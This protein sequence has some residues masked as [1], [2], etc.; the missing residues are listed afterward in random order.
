MHPQLPYQIA[1]T[2]IPQIGPVIARE[3][4]QHFGDALSIFQASPAKLRNVEGLGESRIQ[5]IRSFNQFARAEEECRFVENN[6]INTLFMGQ[7]GYPRRLF[8]CADA[9]ILL[10]ARGMADL[11]CARVLAVVGTRVHTD[12]GRRLTEQLIRDLATENVLILSGLAFGIDALAHK[13]ALRQ[14]LPTAAVLAHGLD[15]LYPP[16]HG[17]LAME[18]VQ[19]AGALIT[20]FPSGT[21][22]DRHHFP[23][24]NR[25]VAGLSD[26]VLVV[27]TGDKGGSLITAE[28]AND[29]N[30]DVFAFPGRVNDPRSAGCNELIRQNKAVLI[31]HA[32]DLLQFMNWV[33]S[34]TRRQSLQ[35]SLFHELNPEE[36]AILDLLQTG[37]SRAI[38]DLNILSRL[39]NSAVAAAILSLELKN[40]IVSLPGKMYRLA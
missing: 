6:K 23:A 25:I 15:Y 22:P 30:R 33:E 21:Q 19:H 2:M 24:R 34:S 11:N 40:L 29:Y 36:K 20:E 32:G 16:Q 13:T 3:L 1:L 26:A 9:P 28:L 37:E 38:D 8:N 14:Q 27:E 10:Y 31:R 7:P 4:L 39:S 5:A 35:T 18:M 12:Y 17:A